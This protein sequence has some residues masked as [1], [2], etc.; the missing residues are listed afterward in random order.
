MWKVEDVIQS[1]RRPYYL[2][3]LVMNLA[4]L[5]FNFYENRKQKMLRKI[6]LGNHLT[7]VGI[8]IH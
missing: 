3:N 8:D 1:S 6:Q 7:H 4:A 2:Q 5:H